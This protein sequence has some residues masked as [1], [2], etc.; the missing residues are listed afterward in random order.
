MIAIVPLFLAMGLAAP[1]SD[2]EKI[3]R[4][5][6]SLEADRAEAVGLRQRLFLAAGEFADAESV[7]NTLD[8]RL[9]HWARDVQ[10]LRADGKVSDAVELDGELDRLRQRW[11]LARE[12]LDVTH[13]ELKALQ[14]KSTALERRITQDQA[15]L[16]RLLSPPVERPGLIA[17]LLEAEPGE[18]LDR[19]KTE[20]RRREER[21]LT[22]A[23]EQ[24]R[25]ADEAARVA[26]ERA[27]SVAERVD[28]LKQSI[29]SEQQLV[30]AARR[31]AELARKTRH[32]L[33]TELRTAAETDRDAL[34]QRMAAADQ[35]H[36]E[37][38]MEERAS[39]DR[40]AEL[41]AELVE[42]QSEQL[43]AATTAERARK[44]AALASRHLVALEAPAFWE[45]VLA[46]LEEHGPVVGFILGGM[47]TLY[48]LV[49]VGSRRI[50]RVVLRRTHAGR[51]ESEDRAETLAG[52]FRSTASVVVVVGGAL[53]LLEQFGLSVGTLLGGA[54][55]IGLAVAFGAQNLVKD[56]FTGF[57][58]LLED[59][60]AVNDAVQINDVSG[61]VEKITLRMTVLRDESGT[62]HFIPHGSITRVSNMS[63]GW[64]RCNLEVRIAYREDTD[65]ALDVLRQLCADVKADPAFGSLILEDAQVLGVDALAESAVVLKL[66]VKTLPMKQGDVRR[67]LLRRI[68]KRFDEL[69]I[70]IPFPHRTVYH[71]G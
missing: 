33:E 18:A 15:E 43:E 17:T 32:D 40:L 19:A 68:K 10:Q 44:E 13:R 69:G 14:E 2:A 64:S 48:W 46:W 49:R 20:D 27:S 65:R 55:I 61:K 31:K 37:A 16:D 57:M 70:E 21:L 67:E 28:A 7:F 5:E 1:G 22:P 24:A 62:A 45:L 36:A 3:A 51:A 59:Q 23:R 50:A 38:G 11:K 53:M 9:S 39:T 30:D 54:A 42:L 56:F 63:Y 8:A 71:R 25:Q 34:R 41:Q 4:L 58:I 6:H 12:R 26:R 35:R 52:V 29:D 47:A 66:L 60:Y